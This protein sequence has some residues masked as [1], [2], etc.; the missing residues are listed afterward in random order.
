[1]I[2]VKILS[3]LQK[4]EVRRDSCRILTSEISGPKLR[5]LTPTST[6]VKSYSWVFQT[7]SGLGPVPSSETESL[8]EMQCHPQ[9]WKTWEVLISGVVGRIL[10]CYA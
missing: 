7:N 10:V 5:R 8:L 4:K 2:L 9:I 3:K 1:M 6:D